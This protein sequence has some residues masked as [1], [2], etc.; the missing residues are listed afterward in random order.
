MFLK[1][2][3]YGGSVQDPE[4]FCHSKRAYSDLALTAILDNKIMSH[5]IVELICSLV[6]KNRKQETFLELANNFDF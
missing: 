6:K 2:M 1:L 5:K 4:L 3:Q